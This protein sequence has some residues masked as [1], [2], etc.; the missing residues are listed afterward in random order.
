MTP[1][2][3]RGKRRSKA[4]RKSPSLPGSSKHLQPSQPVSGTRPSIGEPPR[5]KSRRHRA[6]LLSSLERLPTELL[7]NVFFLCLNV[8]LPRASPSLSSALSSFHVKSQ[9]LLKAFS[10][11]QGYGLQHSEELID[12]LQTKEEVA[13]LQS[14]ILRLRWMTLGFLR[15]CKPMFFETTLLRQFKS[16]QW[17]WVDG[18]P[19]AKLTHAT[20]AKFVKEAYRRAG[21]EAEEERVG[22]LKWTYVVSHEQTIDIR[23]G[24]L[25]GVVWLGETV[26]RPTLGPVKREKR[27][28]LLNCLDECRI[29]EKL[30]HGPWTDEKCEFLTVLEHGRA[31]IDSIDSTSGE[32]AELGLYDAFR[33]RNERAVRL[34]IRNMYRTDYP[35]D[36]IIYNPDWRAASTNATACRHNIEHPVS[37]FTVGIEPKMGYLKSAAIEYNCPIEILG[38][39][40]DPHIPS[41]EWKD[42]ALTT[43]ALEK[44]VQGDERGQW[45][46]DQIDRMSIDYYVL[47]AQM[48]MLELSRTSLSHIDFL[49]RGEISFTL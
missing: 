14:S 26:P 34:I 24:L 38:I 30:L 49:R 46:L 37:H 25:N 15:Q 16:Y 45:L 22:F 20:V 23:F 27:W 31:T 12:I 2:R 43:W 48:R 40:A 28:K 1:I 32:V 44:K 3:I 11:D 6:R 36:A 18:S 8:N 42:A 47:G 29:P 4:S 41:W 7:Q 19:A 35:P 33:V 17:Q 5:K 10:S 9:L 13:N 39:L 21:E